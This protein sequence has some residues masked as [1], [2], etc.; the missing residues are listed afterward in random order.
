MDASS[1]SPP[2]AASPPARPALL[3]AWP[4]SAQLATAFLLGAVTALLVAY[5][6]TAWRGGSRPAQL[7]PRL[8]WY[9]QVEQAGP[10]AHSSPPPSIIPTAGRKEARLRE[11]IDVNEA[12][13]EELQRLPGIGPKLA[14]RILD[15]RGRKPFETVDDLRRVAGIGPKTLEKL[16][17]HV[18]A[19][20]TPLGIAAKE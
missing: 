1:P 11:T 15:E 4:P 18:R 20:N 19:G 16:R 5:S 10:H 12:S 17:P 9:P 8:G 7:E 14:Q 3:T 13:S 6:F 2:P